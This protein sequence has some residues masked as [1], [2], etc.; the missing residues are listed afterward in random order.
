M[1]VNYGGRGHIKTD[2]KIILYD[3]HSRKI[4]ALIFE[5]CLSSRLTTKAEL[6]EGDSLDLNACLGNF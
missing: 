4:E 3:D 2:M 1:I 5:I 6:S